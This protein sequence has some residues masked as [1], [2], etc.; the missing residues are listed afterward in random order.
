VNW[1][2]AWELAGES[3]REIGL[4]MFVFA[5]LDTMFKS[6]YGTKEDWFVAGCVGVLGLILIAIG[7][8][9]GSKI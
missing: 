2:K 4:L 8:V 7:I 9:I 1:K 3:L 5:P 6:A